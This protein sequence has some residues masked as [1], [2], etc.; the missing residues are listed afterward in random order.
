MHYEDSVWRSIYIF[1]RTYAQAQRYFQAHRADHEE[2]MVFI[3]DHWQLR[4]I[5]S[6]EKTL[7]V[8]GNPETLPSYKRI[9][10]AA[11]ECGFSIQYIGEPSCTP[12]F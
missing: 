8:V 3:N 6:K 4:G 1:A 5:D 12:S 2:H 11:K 10:Q 9:I 7:L